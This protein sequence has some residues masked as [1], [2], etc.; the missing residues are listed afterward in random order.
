MNP[1]LRPIIS[2]TL[3]ITVSLTTLFGQSNHK[4]D[5]ATFDKNTAACT[6]FY[7]YVNGGWLAANPIPAA[8]PSWGLG[9]ILNEKNRDLLREILETAAKNTNAKKGSNEQKVG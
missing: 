8:F 2:C 7:Q 1:K 3:L 4:I 5:P 9:N 6:D